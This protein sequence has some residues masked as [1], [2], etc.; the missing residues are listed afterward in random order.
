MAGEA[1]F[2]ENMVVI[3]GVGLIGESL[4]AALKKSFPR[5]RI[6][7]VGRDG[8]RLAQA[9]SMGLLDAFATDADLRT[10][11]HGSPG[12]VCVPVQAIANAASQ[13]LAA[14]CSTVTDAGS[15]KGLSAG[16]CKNVASPALS[17]RTR[18]RAAST[19][20]LSTRML[21][22]LLAACAWYR[23]TISM[24]HTFSVSVRC[25]PRLT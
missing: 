17:E 8:E 19:A 24:E 6:V 25:G 4:A 22:C 13:L 7:G 20:A 23:R 12:V 14:G 3:A 1:E 2:N 9:A 11:P 18:S 16:P 5:C 15:L 10:I 21:N